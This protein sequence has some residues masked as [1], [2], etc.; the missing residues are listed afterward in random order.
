MYTEY[1]SRG[2][3]INWKEFSDTFRKKWWTN[4]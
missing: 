3:Q 2:N 1:L 4:V